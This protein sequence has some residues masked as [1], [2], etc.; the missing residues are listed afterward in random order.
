MN[1]EAQAVR[2]K[3]SQMR[4]LDKKTL[5]EAKSEKVEMTLNTESAIAS[6][7]LIQRLTELYEDPIEAS[8]RETVSNALDAV[9]EKNSGKYPEVRITKPSK[10]NPIMKV[11]DN[12]VGMTYEDL[13]D[14][15]S[16]YGASTKTEDLDQ[17]GAYGL[18]AKA[19]LAYGTEFTVTSVKD[20]QKTTIIVAREETTNYIKIVDSVET[21]EDSGTTVSIPVSNYDIEKFHD[22]IDRYT[23][24]PLEKEVNLYINNK[25][26]KNESYEV[27]SN[28]VLIYDEKEKVY[29][30]VWIKPEEA[31]NLITDLSIDDIRDNMKFVIGGWAYSTPSSRS[32]RG[33]YREKNKN[34]VVELKSG[35]I[36]FNSSRDAITDNER[37]ENLERLMIKYL[38]SDEFMENLIYSVNKMNIDK[39]KTVISTL[40]KNQS[41]TI[42]IKDGE[43]VVEPKRGSYN[44]STPSYYAIRRSYDLAD[45]K[46]NET[47]FGIGDI[48]KDVPKESKNTVVIKEEK[49]SYKKSVT[50]NILSDEL[51]Y[52]AFDTS[53]VTDINKYID[54]VFNDEVD[55]SSLEILMTSIS[56]VIFDPKNK[57]DLRLTFVTNIETDEQITRL[58]NGRKSI[59]RLRNEGKESNVYDSIIVHT[60]HS[61]EDITKMIET[62]KFNDSDV[63]IST[64]E[65]MLE[66]ITNHRSKRI[67]K[68]KRTVNKDLSTRLIEYDMI[69]KTGRACEYKNINDSVPNVII[70]TR[71]PV[72]YN[73]LDM[74]SNW[75]SNEYGLKK[76]EFRL[77][78]SQGFHKASDVDLL[79]EIGEVYKNPD[80]E[81][82]GRSNKTEEFIE[83]NEAG[84]NAILNSD[85]NVEVKSI[86][87]LI[88]GVAGRSPETVIESINGELRLASSLANIASIEFPEDITTGISQLRKHS[89]TIKTIGYS[90]WSLNDEAIKHLLENISSDKYDKIHNI[91]AAGSRRRVIIKDKDNY[92]WKYSDI[93]RG[94]SIQQAQEV[95]NEDNKL[96][97]FNDMIK[98]QIESY[99][100]FIKEV[101]RNIDD[102][103]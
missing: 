101:L 91:T 7:L 51:R 99:I 4:N 31:V 85:S 89:E 65:K 26:V 9:V 14:I 95:Y 15:Y 52:G 100:E 21:N 44:K 54:N 90:N 37:Y 82:V 10:L 29:S 40:L 13:K 28:E 2:S 17:V 69:D 59:V 34:I 72:G 92:E 55:G 80:T 62:S 48:L 102:I 50:N 73:Q 87:R 75:Y 56:S 61:I 11:E 35:I 86:L 45:F 71:N 18:G 33:R 1:N 46:H 84:M 16:K 81:A 39:F 8:V 53:S 60:R 97:I 98:A 49:R 30:R 67:V 23:E 93:S 43:I 66:E 6:G 79:L 94:V 103:V 3:L 32:G 58:K 5:L 24:T 63:V 47:G 20:N 74:I 76:D 22:N 12:G 78:L 96:D 38:S 57:G 27:I 77:Y 68:A 25:L 83:N 42:E 70:A 19:P 41:E 64:A 88:S 36:G